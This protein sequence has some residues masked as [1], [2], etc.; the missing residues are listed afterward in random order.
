MDSID[1]ARKRMNGVSGV[2]VYQEIVCTFRF[3]WNAMK[4]DCQI[5]MCMSW[6]A[7]NDGKHCLN[8]FVRLFRARLYTIAYRFGMCVC[9]IWMETFTTDAFNVLIR[10]IRVS[11]IVSVELH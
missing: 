4:F 10:V 6:I 9:V 8:V 3:I 11:V 1:G 5:C 2:S 7:C